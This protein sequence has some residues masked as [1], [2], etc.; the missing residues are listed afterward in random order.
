MKTFLASFL[1]DWW[2]AISKFFK[3]LNSTVTALLVA[4][5][6]LM[7]LLCIVRFLKPSYS[8]DKNKI[9]ISTLIFAIL[10]GALVIF[11]SCATYG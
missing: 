7:C 5:L 4:L 2:D 3:S 8:S 10:F 1:N 9:K 11:V 6:G